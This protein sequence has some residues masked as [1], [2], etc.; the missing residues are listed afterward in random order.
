M[1]K[2]YALT[3]ESL[4]NP[5]GIDV[6]NPRFSWKIAGDSDG[7]F[8]TE[9]EI[10]VENMWHTCVKSEQS[11]YIEY[12][13]KPLL[14][15]TKYKYKVRVRDNRGEVSDYACGSFTTG[16]MGEALKSKWIGRKEESENVL[17]YVSAVTYNGEKNA[18][19]FATAYG[20]YEIFINGKRVGDSYF[21]PGFTEYHNRL[22][23]QMYDVSKYL[24]MGENRVEVWLGKGWAAGR[25]PFSGLKQPYASVPCFN[26]T[27]ELDGSA[28]LLSDENWRC[29]D[30]PI[31]S[32][33]F[34]D[35]E[36]YDSRLDGV[37]K[38]EKKVEILDYGFDNLVW[39]MGTPVRIQ[40]SIKPVKMLRTPKGE[41]VIDF[42]Q[43][44]AGWAEI[45]ACG[46]SGDKITFTHAEVLDRDGNF[47][48]ENMRS[49]K[50]EVTFIFNGRGEQTY[51]PH[52]SFEGFRYIRIDECSFDVNL[53]NFVGRVIYSDIDINA[54]LETSNK[55]LNRLFLN[56]IW[57]QKGNFIDIPTD[58][59]QRDERAGWTGDA[60]IFIST[61][62]KTGDTH[63]F[64]KKWIMDL[65]AGQS[66]KG[67]VAEF[68]PDAGRKYTSAAYGDAAC[69]CPWELYKAGADK[70]YLKTVYPMMRKWTDYILGEGENEFLWNTGHHFGDWLAL[71]AEDGSYEGITPKD[72]IATAF[73]YFSSSIAKKAATVLGYENEVKYLDKLTRS[74]KK[75]FVRTFLDENGM[76]L[77]RTQT[78]YVIGLHFG[79][80]DDKK[81]A[82][83]E[84]NKMILE[85]GN[86]LKTGF[87]GVGYLCSALSE[88]G[89]TDTAYSLLLQE[90][91]PSWLY[92]VGQG[93]TTIWEHWDGL[94]PDG[95]MWSADMNSFN[96]YSYGSIIDWVYS[97]SL[98]IK[99]SEV[100]YKKIT[101]EPHPDKRLDFCG[102]E[103]DTP[104]GR[105]GS[106]WEYLDDGRVKYTVLVP[107]N[108]TASIILP[109][110]DA[111]E[112]ASGRY[113]FII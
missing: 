69:I 95:T 112:K 46:K 49:A 19:I 61:A 57:S 33:E 59:P 79:L 37:D 21:A 92:S 35:G 52:F 24:V 86:K 71:D 38:N 45:T 44:M 22:Q 1:L 58:C 29:F 76:P 7:I 98:G 47:Y 91:Y 60:Q 63:A 100:G 4:K 73:F 39:N 77:V 9:Y 23:Y 80:L 25:Y 103:F 13:G 84:L 18:Y 72:Y 85:N 14:P 68:V 64:Y 97:V 31:L 74:I 81:R 107:C 54:M 101:V 89:Y 56:T 111:Y 67:L 50:N 28:A 66:E 34:Y 83:Y 70:K 108:T 94:K 87:V 3:C 5:I 20:I 78:A 75:E 51:H 93:A 43:N 30:S 6:P 48:T 113:E 8:Q 15:K 105:V 40:E 27:L 106:K 65:M 53:E 10:T 90:G 16:I 82:A 12:G 32:A 26:F 104:Y 110:G 42:G 41:L 55:K 88:N 11:L 109:N 2:C 99:A 102:G 36:V 96:H 17:K 62:L